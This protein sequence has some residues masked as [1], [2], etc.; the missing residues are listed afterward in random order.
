MVQDE[1]DLFVAC[2]TVAAVTE[3]VELL[4]L[5]GIPRRAARGA[6]GGPKGGLRETAPARGKGPCPEVLPS[7]GALS[8][9]A[10]GAAPAKADLY[11]GVLVIH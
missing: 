1:Y 2:F 4:A 7:L 11:G 10:R 8:L 6:V 9:P 3:S 5:P